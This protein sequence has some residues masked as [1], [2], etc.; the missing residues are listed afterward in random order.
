VAILKGLNATLAFLLELAL[1]A[2]LGYWGYQSNDTVLLKWLLAIGLPLIV[3]V[4]W[5]LYFAPKAA[6]RLSIVPGALLSLGLF[7]LAALALYS[8]NQSMAA[9]VL[10]AFAIVNRVLVLLWRQW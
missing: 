10:A 9:M 2:S 3:I 6:R 8:A 7:L 4:V 5:A 1:I